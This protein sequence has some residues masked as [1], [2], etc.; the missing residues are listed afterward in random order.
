MADQSHMQDTSPPS[1]AGWPQS[2][3]AWSVV[4]LFCVAA[5]LSYTDR[6]ILGLLVDPI[7]ADLK[8]SDTDVG[9]LQGVAFAII[10][11]VAG[12]PLGRL[13]DIFQRRRVI[14]TGVALWSIGT[15]LCGY[16]GSFWMLFAGRLVVG[17]GEAALAPAAMSMIA[18][19]FPT[20]RRGT[21]IGLFAMGMV[22]G[23]GAAI[24]IG[25]TVLGLAGQHDFAGIPL[26]RALAPWRAVLVLL[27]LTGVPVLALLLLVPEPA[28][29][30]TEVS[31]GD[32][33]NTIGAILTSLGVVKSALIPLVLGC[34]LMSVGDFAMLSWAPALLARRYLLPPAAIGFALGLPIVLSGA[35]A[36]LGGGAISDALARRQGPAGRL[37]FAAISAAIALPFALVGLTASADQVIVAVAAWSLFSTCA[38]IVGMTAIQEIVPNRARG[39]SASFISFGNIM[40]GLGGGATLTG[41]VTDHV[42]H[43]PL[44]VGRSLTLV[45]LPAAIAAILLFLVASRAARSLTP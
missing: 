21:A 12:L 36:S 31:A 10:Y 15:I 28:R 38:G 7:R 33:G 27:G 43:D 23:G 22:I 18:D 20:A 8:I 37:G 42:F 3:Q 17:V 5:I 41:Y 1:A 29:H 25:G 40:L 4:G 14:L 30:R 44:S 39:L 13:A 11:S 34:A 24:S 35:L 32:G 9:V 2:A 26:L 45:I 19:M 6:Q 16:A